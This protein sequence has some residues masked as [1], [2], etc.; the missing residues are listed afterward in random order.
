M[1]VPFDIAGGAGG[2][3]GTTNPGGISGDIQFNN[4]G[5]FGG[6]TLVPL[7]HGGTNADLSASGSATA[8]LAQD[9]AHAITARNLVAADIPNLD[10]AKI[11]TGQIA[12]A[13]GGT[14][15]DLSGTGGASK[16]L[17]QASAGAAVTVVQPA[18]TDLSGTIAAAQISA[19]LI[20]LTT[21]VTGI[22]PPANG[23]VANDTTAGGG[24]LA[25][26]GFAGVG[27][28]ASTAVMSGA[29]ACR[30]MQV[31]IDRLV[32]F[33]KAVVNVTATNN[34]SKYFIGIY[35]K[36]GTTLLY[37][38]TVSL[39]ASTGKYTVAISGTLTPGTYWMMWSSDST[40]PTVAAGVA[41]GTA[42]LVVFNGS[43]VRVGNSNQTVS[44]GV[45]PSGIGTI[46]SSSVAPPM[47]FFEP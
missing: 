17:K 41:V 38:V 40:L 43:V 24:W 8:V 31:E 33:T 47:V 2:G 36:A 5:S 23:G 13:Q 34:G 46:T 3:S 22:L 39:T 19:G 28:N 10:A 18:F 27:N 21:K 37:Q 14:N 29:N 30:A 15:A 12:L 11:A 45:M 7:S 6:E 42:S 16:F 20:D 44:A 4:A 1:S 26:Y 35:D 9:A 32:T 25:P